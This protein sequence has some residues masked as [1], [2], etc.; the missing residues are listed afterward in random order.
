MNR[1]RVHRR[2]HYL[3]SKSDSIRSKFKSA[4]S[5]EEGLGILNELLMFLEQTKQDIQEAK[6]EPDV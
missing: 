2:L 5:T 6:Q 3:V 1:P 4:E